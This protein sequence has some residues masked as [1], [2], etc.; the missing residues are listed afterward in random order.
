MDIHH[1][2][3]P[4]TKDTLTY[5]LLSQNLLCP[6]KALIN[7]RFQLTRDLT[8]AA[9]AVRDLQVFFTDP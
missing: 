5:R 6:E 7:E 8:S 4:E 3:L 2:E 1:G 9:R